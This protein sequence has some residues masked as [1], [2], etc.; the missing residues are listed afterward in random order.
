MTALLAALMLAPLLQADAAAPVGKADAGK[1]T[2]TNTAPYC[3]NCHGTN[4]EGGFGP[5][6][7]GRALSWSQFKRAVR[8]PWGV[9]PAYTE[10]QLTEQRLADM[11]AY[12]SG[13]PRLPDAGQ[14]R[15]QVTPATPQGQ[16]AA[17]QSVGCAQCHQAE[18]GQPRRYMGG[19]GGDFKMFESLVYEH[20]QT[21]A[22]GRMGNY[23][24][25]R[26]PEST[27]QEIWKFISSDLGLRA[28]VDASI[29]AGV[30]SGANKVY[31]LTV[32]NSGKAGKGLA[33]EDL[34]VSVNLPAGVTVVNATGT[35]YKGVAPGAGGSVASWQVAKLAAAEKQTF[36]LTLAGTGDGLFKG[37]SVKWSKPELHRPANTVKQAGIP[38]AGDAV[39]VTI[40]RPG[41]TQ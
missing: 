27:L 2:W 40:A 28:S 11:Y 18:L 14:P 31:T 16:I 6:L 7:A 39:D 4:G 38:D 35:G 24:R 37:S 34:T 20:T 32:S 10:A 3:Q 22:T 8:Q 29:D 5:D 9:M 33:A 1:T 21:F 12:L 26:L 30:A 23:S 25:Q 41:A 36:A 17:I 19:E 13:L 15:L